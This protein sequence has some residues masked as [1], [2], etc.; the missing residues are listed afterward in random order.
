ME[1]GEQEA[2]D[3][4][5]I[6]PVKVVLDIDYWKG[7]NYS[8]PA[9]T[10]DATIHGTEAATSED[11]LT[12]Q[13]VSTTSWGNT[14]GDKPNHRRVPVP[15]PQG[16]FGTRFDIKLSFDNIALDTVQVYY[17]EQEDPR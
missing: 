6:R 4:S 14:T 7:G 2:S 12:Q 15:L 1:L 10:V 16:Q 9:I 11:S 17:E 5:V 8:D 13:V 3:G